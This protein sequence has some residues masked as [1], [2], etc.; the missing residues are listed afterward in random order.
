MERLEVPEPR[1]LEGLSPQ[2]LGR[3][4]SGLELGIFPDTPPA[5]FYDKGLRSIPTMFRMPELTLFKPLIQGDPHTRVL[6]RLLVVCILDY[7]LDWTDLDKISKRYQAAIHPEACN[8]NDK[9][10]RVFGALKACPQETVTRGQAALC[11]WSIG[12]GMT[13]V[14]R[15]AVP[16]LR[17]PFDTPAEW[18]PHTAAMA[19]GRSGSPT[20]VAR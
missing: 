13:R 15:G 5:R 10:G 4:L 12:D 9:V 6:R 7:A 18:G 3:R 17:R 14:R 20:T 19:L 8:D 11:L 16:G 1:L 2:S